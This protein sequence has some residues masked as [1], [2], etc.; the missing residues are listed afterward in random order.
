M[1]K[2]YRGMIVDVVK[3]CILR[4]EIV[5]EDGKILAIR[6]DASAPDDQ[7]FT[8]GLVDA[9]VHVESSL[10]APTEFA[11]A[12]VVHGTVATVSDP[13]EIANVLGIE[14]V[15][16]MITDAR[17]SPFKIF[18]G[19][20]S[21][22]P[23]TPFET[24]G[25]HFGPLEVAQL[26][27]LPDIHYLS[28]VMNFPAVIGGDP[29]LKSIIEAAKQRAMPIDGHAP[30]VMG[31]ALALYYQAGITTDHECVTLEEAIARAERGMF[32]AI[33][34]GSAARNYDALRPLLFSHPSQCFFCSDDKHPD[35]LVLGHINT[36]LR[37]SVAAG[38]DPI[39]AIK[40]ATLNPIRHY[41]LPVG[42]LQPGDPA[43]FVCW[44]NLS[45]FEAKA[46]YID[47]EPVAREGLSLLPRLEIETINR[48]EQY[49]VSAE[50][51]RLPA[52][53]GASLRVIE[54]RDGQLVTGQSR[55]KPTVREGYVMADPARDLLKI[56]VVNRYQPAPVAI[57][58][59]RNFGLREGAIASS[60][61]HDS[62]NVV[63]VGANDEDL[64]TAINAV[65]ADR[66]GLAAV[67]QG[68]TLTLPL[69]VAG[70]MSDRDAAWVAERFTALNQLAHA[71]GSPM[72]APFMTLSFMALL[73]IPQL[74]LSD[75]GLFDA[76][77]F[78]LIDPWS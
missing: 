17:R 4:G 60:V 9:H 52:K 6:E 11:R 13:H 78:A 54:A 68:Q 15:K 34:E 63:A 8:P 45:D 21:C 27:D 46:V 50:E 49:M 18:F 59:I 42:L 71:C 29:A 31:E 76:E 39:T 72:R 62:H 66:G 28:E 70:L 75:L 56:A 48:F 14:G 3:G 64:R 74:K 36:L 67:G 41:R 43:D 37:R 40:A 16:W 65:M 35:D 19:A 25:A 51:L 69:P 12:S 32:V 30:G 2:N 7:F 73:V 44:N 23:A 20:P 38:V 33:R 57:A 10:L 24:A 58:L 1:A 61:A 5:V 53:E 55:E 47:G 22:V 26:L 77:P